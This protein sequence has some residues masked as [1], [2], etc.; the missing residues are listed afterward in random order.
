MLEIAEEDTGQLLLV[1]DMCSS[2]LL[3]VKPLSKANGN[4]C[5]FSPFKLID[6]HIWI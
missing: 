4:L 6:F 2:Q 1:S 3:L 5:I